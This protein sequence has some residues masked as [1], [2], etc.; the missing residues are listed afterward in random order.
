MSAC[1]TAS[2]TGKTSNPS[3]L[4]CSHDRPGRRPMITSRPES[5]RLR[6]WPRPWDPYPITAIR[7]PCRAPMSASDS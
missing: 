6:D 5:R 7:F 2:A 3:P 4:A 1:F